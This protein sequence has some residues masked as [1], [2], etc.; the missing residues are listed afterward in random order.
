MRQ[1]ASQL[2]DAGEMLPLFSAPAAGGR[3]VHL[4]EYKQRQQLVLLLLHGPDC[5]ACRELLAAFAARYT[6]FRE[7]AT[8]VLALLPATLEAVETLQGQLRLPFPLLADAVGAIFERL[9]AWESA[10]RAARPALLVADRYGALY[11][12]YAADEAGDLPSPD[13]VLKDLE[14]IA[15]QCPE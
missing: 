9:G 13:V 1:S 3:M 10:R 11:A 15:L 14:Y 8:E 2:I 12:R 5:P 6:D 4:W 7:Q